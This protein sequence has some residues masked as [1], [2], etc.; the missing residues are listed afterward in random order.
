MESIKTQPQFRARLFNQLWDM[1]NYT[2]YKP[3][4]G[5]ISEQLNDNLS[6]DLNSHLWKQIYIKLSDQSN[7]TY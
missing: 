7:E 5:P 4:L 2:S 6:K 3:L 1:C